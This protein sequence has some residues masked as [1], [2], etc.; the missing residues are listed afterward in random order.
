MVFSPSF[1]CPSGTSLFWFDPPI[2]VSESV[3]GYLEWER[4]MFMNP[5]NVSSTIAVTVAV[6]VFLFLL[7]YSLWQRNFW[8]GLFVFNLGN[9]LKIT[10]SVV[11]GGDSGVAAVVPTMSS[12][13]IL[14]LIAFFVWR[15]AT[16]RFRSER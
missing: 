15:W 5:D 1:Y 7:F 8:I 2:E 9:I 14:N 6:C 4:Q 11:F 10:V 3:S 13:L 16:Q 12:V